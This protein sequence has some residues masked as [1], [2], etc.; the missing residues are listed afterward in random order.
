VAPGSSAADD[1][2]IA[3]GIA[4]DARRRRRR[5]TDAE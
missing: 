5:D 2:D 3:D 4:N 1:E